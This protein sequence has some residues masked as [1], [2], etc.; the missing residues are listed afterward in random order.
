MGGC[1]MFNA[2]LGSDCGEVVVV[3]GICNFCILFSQLCCDI[4]DLFLFGF[5]FL[6]YTE[7]G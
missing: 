2:I 4:L 7:Q 5:V 1:C 3:G 6:N